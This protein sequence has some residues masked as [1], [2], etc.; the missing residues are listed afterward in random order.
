MQGLTHGTLQLP[1]TLALGEATLDQQRSVRDV[2]RVFTW[3]R[4]LLE[5][6]VY[7][8]VQSWSLCLM[9]CAHVPQSWHKHCFNCSS[10][11]KKLDSTTVC[12]KDGQIYCK[13]ERVCVCVS[14]YTHMFLFP[15]SMLWEAFWAERSRIWTGSRHTLNDLNTSRRKSSCHSKIKFRSYNYSVNIGQNFYTLF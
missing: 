11:N 4:R 3:Q 2:A 14:P 5:L 13:C 10:C 7:V 1:R 6:E 15:I 12:D 8:S 9:W